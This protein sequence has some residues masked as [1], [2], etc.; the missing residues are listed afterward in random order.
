MYC[1]TS[2]GK[3]WHTNQAPILPE[4]K[5]SGHRKR[6]ENTVESRLARISGAAGEH[7]MHLLVGQ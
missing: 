4:P 7:A 5:W 3:T 1:L 2:D 6:Y